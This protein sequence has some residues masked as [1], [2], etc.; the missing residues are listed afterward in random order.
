V[1]AADRALLTRARRRLTVL[2][3]AAVTGALLLVGA[4]VLVV[5]TRAEQAAVE[6]QLAAACAGAD[7][8]TDPPA[9]VW[10]AIRS[11]A[12]RVSTTVG[13]PAG[14]PDVRALA[15]GGFREDTVKAAGVTY[16]VRTQP[17]GPATVQAAMSVRDRDR[18]RR[19]LLG[20]VAIAEL[21]GLAASVLIGAVLGRRALRPLAEALDRQRRFVADA[22]HELRTPVTHLHT[23]AQLLDRELRGSEL[24]EDSAR[25]VAATH[26]L[27]EVITDLLTS[28]EL[29]HAPDRYGPVDLGAIAAAA[30]DE[31]PS[32]PV[33]LRLARTGPAMVRGSATALHRVVAA[34]VD[35]ALGHTSPGGHVTVEVGPARRQVRLV[36]RDDGS[37][38]D[39]ADTER[40]FDRFARGETGSGRRYG[41][42]LALVREIVTA[43]G[44][45]VTAAGRPGAGAEFT[46]L[47]PAAGPL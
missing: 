5:E 17:R 45:T 20:S 43:H 29:D 31:Q 23:R 1:S 38:L 26:R 11:A 3:A 35:N 37:G 30:V 39:P 36:V 32:G 40:I 14:L 4:L 47:L 15:A 28:A 12:G 8:V 6:D 25:L 44:G 16:L 34:L 46:V 33:A 42:G 13:T 22:S 18:D 9:G 21:A 10:L 27:G 41:L 19:R 2:S 24:G 7:D